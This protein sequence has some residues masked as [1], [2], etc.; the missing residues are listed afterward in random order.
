MTVRSQDGQ[1]ILEGRCRVEDAEALLTALQQQRDGVVHLDK[2]ETIHSALVQVLLTA[3]PRIVG[4]SKH[5]FLTK[6]GVLKDDDDGS[7][8]IGVSQSPDS[9]ARRI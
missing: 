8:S 1:I 5:E 4:A 9:P 7:G 3:K 6:Y 2:A